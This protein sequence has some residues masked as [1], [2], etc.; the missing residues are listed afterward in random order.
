MVVNC[1]DSASNEEQKPSANPE[2]QKVFDTLPHLHVPPLDIGCSE[3]ET[4]IAT[5]IFDANTRRSYDTGL[6]LLATRRTTV[7]HPS[8][9][10]A[11]HASNAARPRARRVGAPLTG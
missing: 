10:H 3:G 2:G 1:Y 9:V 8:D 7:D 5:P 6:E 4:T 11:A